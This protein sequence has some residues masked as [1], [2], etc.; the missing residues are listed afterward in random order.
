MNKILV[1]VSVGELF[2]KITILEIKKEYEDLA[3]QYQT[4]ALVQFSGTDFTELSQSVADGVI[5][6][7]AKYYL[8][9]FESEGNSDIQVDY[10]LAIQPISQSWT[11][12]T[13]KFGDRPKNTNGC[14]WENRSNPIGGTAV[15]WA[16]VGTT[17][18]SVEATD[19]SGNSA[20]AQTSIIVVRSVQQPYFVSTGADFVVD[21]FDV[22]SFDIA[23]E[24][25][26]V[27]DYKITSADL[28]AGANVEGLTFKWL[29]KNADAGQL[30]ISFVLEV[31]GETVGEAFVAAVTVGS[32]N[33]SPKI[34]DIANGKV[35]LVVDPTVE[36]GFSAFDPDPD[37]VLEFTVVRIGSRGVLP[38]VKDVVSSDEDGGTR[39]TGV[40]EWIPDAVLD[41]DSIVRF[42]V[43]VT[44]GELI[45]STQFSYGEGA[46][47]TQTKLKLAQTKYKSRVFYGVQWH[48][49]ARPVQMKVRDWIG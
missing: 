21:A 15:T 29:P 45:G 48:P 34:A 4:R 33:R 42:K 44:D 49:M 32:V 19:Q 35:D 46:V 22:L 24:N 28:P 14:S 20:T 23:V 7:A 13:G 16:D 43:T 40:L 30:S 3:F 2:D 37:S 10:K 12:G 25:P 18:L 39:V 9:L 38:V 47:N 1:E 26:D 8:R 41:L 31:G 36:I 6:S 17:V 5:P 27:L 11:E